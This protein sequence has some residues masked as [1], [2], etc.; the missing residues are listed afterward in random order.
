MK[1][2]ENNEY[3]TDSLV[4]MGAFMEVLLYLRRAEN[5]NFRICEI[6]AARVEFSVSDSRKLG[7]CFLVY[8]RFFP[9]TLRA[10]IFSEVVSIYLQRDFLAVPI[11]SIWR[12]EHSPLLPNENALLE[13]DFKKFKARSMAWVTGRN[14]VERRS[15]LSLLD[16]L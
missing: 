5:G 7:R 12:L 13:R 2:F 9:E 11:Y 10:V 8:L 15:M 14:K 3:T 16:L 4:Q 6:L 1:F